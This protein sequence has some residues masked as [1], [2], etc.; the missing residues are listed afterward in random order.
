MSSSSRRLTAVLALLLLPGPFAAAV[1]PGEKANKNQA[2]DLRT[3]LHG[4]PL[5]AGALARLGMVQ[6]LHPASVVCLAVSPDGKR[7]ACGGDDKT[8]RL[9]D[10][11][12]GRFL[13]QFV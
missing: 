1:R 7:L 3:D 11:T 5:P 12:T 2:K 13:R 10:A 4:D 8:V 9:L 6:P